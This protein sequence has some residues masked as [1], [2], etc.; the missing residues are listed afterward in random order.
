MQTKYLINNE[1][2]NRL[3]LFFTGWSTDWRIL[4]DVRIPDG[5]DL[6]IVWDYRN[7]APFNILKKY[8]ETVVLA[9]SF[10]VYA[11]QLLLPSLSSGLNITGRWAVNGS[12]N[13]I[14]PISGIPPE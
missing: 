11:A 8:D 4:S 9:W 10:G 13:P 7:P 5:Y 6:L 3:I 14:D 1:E 12:L 2:N